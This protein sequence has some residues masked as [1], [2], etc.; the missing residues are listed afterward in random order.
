MGREEGEGSGARGE[1]GTKQFFFFV[2]ATCFQHLDDI[3]CSNILL[4]QLGKP[5]GGHLFS[6]FWVMLLEKEKEKEE[7]KKTL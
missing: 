4:H 2:F 7:E 3:V 1:N 5:F 6:M